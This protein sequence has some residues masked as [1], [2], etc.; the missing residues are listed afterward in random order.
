[1]WDAVDGVIAMAWENMEDY[2]EYPDSRLHFS[3][4]E[5]KQSVED[6]LYEKDMVLNYDKQILNV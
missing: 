5:E 1:M 4:G 3:F 2:D 6:K